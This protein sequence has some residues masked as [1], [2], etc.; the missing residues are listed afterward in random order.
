MDFENVTREIFDL[1]MSELPDYWDGKES[2]LFMRDNGCRNWRQMEWPGWY[3]QFMCE[4]ILSKN[5]YFLIPGPA[6][7]NVEFD[8]FREIPWDF[9]AH[10]SNTGDKV[11]TNGYQEV[12]FALN[13]YGYVGF[14][15]AKGSAVFDDDNQTFKKWHDDLKGKTSAYEEERILRGAP[16]RRRK[17]SFV[18]ESIDFII[19]DPTTINYCGSFQGGMRNSNGTAR[20][21]KVMLDMADRR[22]FHISYEVR[23]N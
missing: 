10:T 2:I 14:I 13:D 19:I 11:P 16:S 6:Y 3:F 20:N 5:N 8:G 21:P 22:V 9:K 1:L 15:I 18:L 23:G 12:C 4:N 17:A 7:G